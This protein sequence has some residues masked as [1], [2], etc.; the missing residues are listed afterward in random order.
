VKVRRRRSRE[1]KHKAQT[2]CRGKYHCPSPGR[3]SKTLSER[4][5]TSSVDSTKRIHAKTE[6]NARQEKS[7]L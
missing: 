3:T 1:H 7:H 5:R 2:S 4:K 6:K